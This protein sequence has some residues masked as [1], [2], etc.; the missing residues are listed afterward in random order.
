MSLHPY[1]ERIVAEVSRALLEV[2]TACLQ[3]GTGGGK[4][5]TAA[6]LIRRAVARGYRVL[7]LAHLDTLVEDTHDRLEAAGV[8]TGYVQAGRPVDPDAP[9]QV[10]SVQT[11]HA[12]TCHPPADLVLADEAHRGASRMWQGIFAAYPEAAILGLTATPQRADGRA[13][14]DTYERLVVGPT[15]RELVAQGHLVPC[16]VLAP[17]APPDGA[18]A[19]DPV[20]AYVAHTP[21]RRAIVFAAN[22]AHAR[23]LRARFEA[24]GYPAACIVGETSREVRRA[25]REGIASG[26]LRVVVGVSVFLEGWDVPAAEVV[27]LARPFSSCGSYL[28]AVGRGLRVAPGKDRCTVIDL[29]GAVHLHG[30]PEDDRRWSLEGGAVTLAEALP[31]LMRCSGCLAVFRPRPR[32]P[33]CGADVRAEP[34]LPRVLR[35]A[36]KLANVSAL[37]RSERDRRYLAAM[38]RRRRDLHPRAAW[39]WAR[40]KFTQQHGREPEV[41]G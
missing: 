23:D 17:P 3:L 33:R 2:R 28:Q 1:Q 32:C 4:T 39:A 37:P 34:K 36:E 26:A 22:V 15:N 29:R 5:Y 7:F 38:A 30:L 14:G 6:E 35:R 41:A 13:L 9:A 19:A 12:R 8:R 10:A 27:I 24:A 16:E 20:D 21:G 11:L 18:L 25:V 31:A 40:Q